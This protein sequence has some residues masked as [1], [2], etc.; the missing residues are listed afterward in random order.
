M[1]RSSFAPDTIPSILTP[2]NL[3]LIQIQY[4]VTPEYDF[5]PPSSED[6]EFLYLQVP[7]FHEKLVVLFLP[8]MDAQ[9]AKMLTKGLFT[10]K[11]NGRVQEDGSK[12]AKV[13]VSS[14]RVF[15]PTVTASEVI[16]SIEIALT[17]EVDTASMGSVPS[18][19][20]GPSSGDRVLEL[21]VRKET[22]EE[23]K[24][25][26][27]TKISC[28]ARL[29][30]PDGNDNEQGKDPF[31]NSEII[32]ELADSRVIRCSLTSIGCVIKRRRHRRPRR[33]FEPSLPPSLIHYL[34]GF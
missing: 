2:D 14:P 4:G 27:I 20:L 9:A 31:D 5:E 22:G 33:T 25:K 7:S 21:P 15:T 32:W 17:A 28:K 19:P 30:K 18:M 1:S 34:R 23:R 12:R 13:G 3:F 10:R 8:E 24:K 11:R 26:A 6:Q 29:G 16:V